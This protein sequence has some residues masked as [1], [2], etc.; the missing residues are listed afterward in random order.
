MNGLLDIAR[1]GGPLETTISPIGMAFVQYSR[2][3]V[4]LDGQPCST[5]SSR[6]RNREPVGEKEVHPRDKPVSPSEFGLD[7]E[8]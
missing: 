8:N 4:F 3:A 7:H 2:Q 6:R 5:R 1:G